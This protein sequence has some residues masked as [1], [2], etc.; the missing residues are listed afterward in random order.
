MRNAPTMEEVKATHKKWVL[1]FHPNKNM[2]NVVKTTQLF[3]GLNAGYEDWKRAP[4]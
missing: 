3:K 2:N 4:V 1:R